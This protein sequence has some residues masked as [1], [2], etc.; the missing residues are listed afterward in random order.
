[1]GIHYVN[2]HEFLLPYLSDLEKCFPVG[3]KLLNDV[4]LL[5]G[6][7]TFQAIIR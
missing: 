2:L 6:S 7:E 4:H 5:L 3:D 1:L